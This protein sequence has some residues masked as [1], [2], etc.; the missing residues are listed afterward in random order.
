MT[1]PRPTVHFADTGEAAD[2]AAFL[3]RLLHY[4]K[5]AA[6]RVQATGTTLAVFGRPA[7]FEVLAIRTARLAKPYE[8]GLDA[9]LDLTASAG[10]LLERIDEGA[11]TALVPQPVTGPSWAGV[12]PPRG[13]WREVPG[14]PAP[15]RIRAAVGAAVA[16]F[17]SRTEQLAP[18]ERTRE[19][20]DRIGNDLWSRSLGE[21]GL[22]LRAAHA[23]HSLGFLRPAAPGR[24]P[25]LALLA[26]GPWLR[27]RTDYGSVA[28]RRSGSSAQLSVTPAQGRGRRA[29]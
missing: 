10:E 13:G 27:L 23:A 8:H 22:P 11:G 17:R 4:D 18:E 2:L 9:V 3:T 15:E 25:V 12:L 19:A 16:E 6:V 26:T 28:V 7:S 21:G 1:A 20:L 14:L 24:E 29:G 5:A